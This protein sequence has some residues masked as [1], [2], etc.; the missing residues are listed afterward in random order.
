MPASQWN[1]FCRQQ[2]GLMHSNSGRLGLKNRLSH[3]KICLDRLKFILWHRYLLRVV[4]D[5]AN[6]AGHCW[7][8]Q[9]SHRSRRRRT[10]NR[11]CC[12]LH[13]LCLESDRYGEEN[14]PIPEEQ[15]SNAKTAPCWPFS[16]WILNTAV[17]RVWWTMLGTEMQL[18]GYSASSLPT[19]EIP[20]WFK[21]IL[22]PYSA[23]SV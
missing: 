6:V 15:E 10:M 18:R 3:R 17:Q 19:L 7:G 14:R 21:S 20:M 11:K 4:E 1:I 12:W 9:C 5:R 23:F 13:W 16:G 22:Q 2:R 8:Q